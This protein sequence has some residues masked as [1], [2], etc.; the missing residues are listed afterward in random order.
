MTSSRGNPRSRRHPSVT[1]LAALTVTVALVTAGTAPVHAAPRPERP[2]NLR[3]TTLTLTELRLDWD[4]PADSS[5][6]VDYLIAYHYPDPGVT[7]PVYHQIRDGKHTRTH[8][9]VRNLNAADTFPFT[10]TAVT[11]TGQRSAPARITVRTLT[12]DRPTVT[13][14]RIQAEMDFVHANWNDRTG[15]GHKYLYIAHNN[16]TNWVSQALHHGYGLSMDSRWYYR[17]SAHRSASWTSQTALAA[18]MTR[19]RTDWTRHS[20]QAMKHATVGTYI[21]FDWNPADDIR[22]HA[23][24]VTYIQENPDGSRT[25]FYASSTTHALYRNVTWTTTVRRP[26]G[27]LIYFTPPGSETVPD[28]APAP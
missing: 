17:D 25:V 13:D 11:A 20:D 6:I 1:R 16:C 7:A 8:V 24:I 4:P 5:R 27:T 18:Y 3:I 21:S 26:G 19:Y 12:P 22:N 15:L 14:P 2:T 28:A 9:T 23:A 10:V